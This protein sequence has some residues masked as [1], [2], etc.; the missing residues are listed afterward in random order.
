MAVDRVTAFLDEL[1]ELSLLTPAQLD[2]LRRSPPS[3]LQNLAKQL[4]LRGWL[5]RFQAKHLLQGHSKQLVVGPYRLLDAVGQGGM[6]QGFKAHHTLMNRVVALKI[7]RK[8][9]LAKP[10]TVA[11]FQREVQLAAQLAHANIVTAYDAGREG[12]THYFAME[13]VDGTDLLHLVVAS[14]QL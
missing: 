4:V 6:G 1:Q 12:E 14:G 9:K 11:R 2:E 13:Y 5:T 8:E 3:N 7:I 10:Q